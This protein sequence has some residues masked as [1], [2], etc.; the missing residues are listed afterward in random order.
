MSNNTVNENTEIP[1]VDEYSEY[2][3][4]FSPDAFWDKMKSI[5]KR[6]GRELLEAALKLFYVTCDGNTPT[7]VK[8]LA[9]GA[10]G[11]LI[12]PIDVVPDFIPAVGLTDDLAVLVGAL[13]S[14]R[15]HIKASHVE[16]AD[17][18]LEEWFG[19]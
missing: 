14:A 13:S 1:E 6:A 17:E 15:A 10:L 18:K 3:E 2:G 5:L 19:S 12:L 16:Q 11:Y 9:V 8:A 7:W 4:N